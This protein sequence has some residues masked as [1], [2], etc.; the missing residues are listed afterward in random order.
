MGCINEHKVVVG[1]HSGMFSNMFAFDYPGTPCVFA[2][3]VYLR[4]P[5]S[6]NTAVKPRDE[7]LS[8]L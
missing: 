5:H 6:L 4:R 2:T 1:V 3:V 8:D 7:E